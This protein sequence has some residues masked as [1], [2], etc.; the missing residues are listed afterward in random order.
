MNFEPHKDENFTSEE[1]NIQKNHKDFVGKSL[2]TR[3]Y[4]RDSLSKRTPQNRLLANESLSSLRE[5]KFNKQEFLASKPILE[6]KYHHPSFRNNNL[7]DLFNNQP[8][9][10]LANY[11]TESETIKSNIDKF[12]S[13]LLMALLTKK[14]SYQNAN[15]WIKKL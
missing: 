8:E 6:V 4:K 11:F 7:F 2:D 9:Y 15:K 5:V 13:N 10:V 3:S 14:L 1:Q 12:L